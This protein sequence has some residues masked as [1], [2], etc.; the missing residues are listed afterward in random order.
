MKK[1]AAQSGK[2]KTRTGRPRPKLLAVS[3]EMRHWSAMLEGEMRSWPNVTTKPMFGFVSFYRAGKIFAA[4]PRT[5]G[6][7]TAS[8]VILKFDP[9]PSPLLEKAQDEPRMDTSTR[10]PGKGWFSF[11]LTSEA[12][13][14]DALWWLSHAYESAKSRAR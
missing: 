8:S 10:I 3:E 14:R 6:F 12:D 13:L 4:T 5:R 2:T 11:A 9:M 1:A 7:G